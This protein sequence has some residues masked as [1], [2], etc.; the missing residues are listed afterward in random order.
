[1]AGGACLYLHHRGWESWG[2]AALESKGDEHQWEAAEEYAEASKEATQQQIADRANKH[3]SH[4]NRV[5]TMVNKREAELEGL[6]GRLDEVCKATGLSPR[7]VRYRMQ[8]VEQYPEVGKF[9]QTFRTWDSFVNPPDGAHVGNNAGE[10]E[11]YTPAAYIEAAVA[12]MG[13]IDLDRTSSINDVSA[14]PH[15]DRI[16]LSEGQT[17]IPGSSPY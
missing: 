2:G 7:E 5:L 1:M 4:I 15:R 17:L 13:G 6:N 3:V 11:W 16:T 8:A 9:L 14:P 10:N 12:V